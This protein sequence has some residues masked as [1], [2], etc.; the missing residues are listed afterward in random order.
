MSEADFAYEMAHLDRREALLRAQAAEPC[1]EAAPGDAAD[2]LRLEGRP[3]QVKAL[4]GTLVEQIVVI[5]P[6]EIEVF[7][8]FRKL[9]EESGMRS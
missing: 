9:T 5:S 2:F 7:V 4:L 8:T 1:A 3:D 6:S